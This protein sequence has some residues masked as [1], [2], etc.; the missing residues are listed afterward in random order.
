MGSTNGVAEVTI[1]GAGTEFRTSGLLMGSTS[2]NPSTNI[3]N[4]VSGGKLKVNRFRKNEK[5]AATSLAVVNANG[6]ILAPTFSWRLDAGVSNSNPDHFVVWENGLIVDTT[7]NYINNSSGAGESTLPYV[8]EKPTGK[9]VESITLPDLTG[10]TYIGI[11]RIVI[12]DATG[13]GASAYAEFD[14]TTKTLTHVVVTSR[15]CNYSDNAK[16]YLE[17][18]AGTARYECALTLSDNTGRCGPIVKRGQ[19]TLVL[20]STASDIDGGYVVEEGALWLGRVPSVAVPVRVESGAALNLNKQ[21]NI[22]ISTLE[23]AGTVTN[24]NATVVG[25]IKAKCADLFA[26][27]HAAF[28]ANLTL[29]DGAVFEITDAENLD[30]YE[31][32]G[33]VVALSAGGTISGKPEL[34]LTTSAGTAYAGMTSWS[35]AASADGKSFRFGASKGMVILLK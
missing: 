12:E 21:G 20:G 5:A 6:G 7:E 30:A 28:T 27:R 9:G 35:L 10:K 8:F 29:S 33:R 18:P 23:G 32:A 1:S 17:S 3:L 26:G 24:G 34:R 22:T 2:T 13:W 4:L 25:V 16:A 15:G 14:F 31:N 11:G 19:P